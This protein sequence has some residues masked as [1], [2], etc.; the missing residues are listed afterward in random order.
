MSQSSALHRSNQPSQ[1]S[2]AALHRTKRR[3]APQPVK[4]MQLK[5][6]SQDPRCWNV[7][8]SQFFHHVDLYVQWWMASGE[9]IQQS[10]TSAGFWALV[11]P[12]CKETDASNLG[13]LGAHLDNVVKQC[14][15]N[16]LDFFNCARSLK[17]NVVK[18]GGAASPTH[19]FPP[20]R[21]DFP[22]IS[23]WIFKAPACNP[24]TWS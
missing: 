14:Y 6:T 12:L 7:W 22:Q 20:L 16:M 18:L 21:D 5:E 11:N 8:V 24:A 15:S 3:A 2:Q 17:K 1:P 19:L 13:W 10:P 23:Q 4:I 9:A